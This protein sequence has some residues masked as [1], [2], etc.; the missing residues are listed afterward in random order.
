MTHNMI[1]HRTMATVYVY[2]CRFGG[3]TI[4]KSRDLRGDN[5][6]RHPNS[7][8]EEHDFIFMDQPDPDAAW[9]TTDDRSCYPCTRSECSSSGGHCK[10]ACPIGGFW[11]SSQPALRAATYPATPAETT[12]AASSSTTVVPSSS[13][14]PAASMTPRTARHAARVAQSTCWCDCIYMCVHP[15]LL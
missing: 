8:D 1:H 15:L 13:S 11:G 3:H 14:A 5:E 4:A 12:T 2:N 7:S 6:D 9:G 10:L